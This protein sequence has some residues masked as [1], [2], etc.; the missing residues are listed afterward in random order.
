M[1]S[2]IHGIPYR[3]SPDDSRAQTPKGL[4]KSLEDLQQAEIPMLDCIYLFKEAQYSSED[5]RLLFCQ[6]TSDNRSPGAFF[7]QNATSLVMTSRGGHLMMISST[8]PLRY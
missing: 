6:E 3:V 1:R 4:L 5:P 7:S 8:S 2:L